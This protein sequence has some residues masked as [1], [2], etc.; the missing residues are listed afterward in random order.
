[1]FPAGALF[2]YLATVTAF[3][4]VLA[5]GPRAQCVCPDG[6]V[7]LF[8]PDSFAS[9]CCC[10]LSTADPVGAASSPGQREPHL[11]CARVK[12]ESS[13]DQTRAVERCGCHRV[14]VADA[15]YTAEE[16]GDGDQFE[17]GTATWT[18]RPIAPAQ[19]S[20][21]DRL[22]RRFLLPPPDRVILFR[23]FTC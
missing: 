21:F 23:H 18:G 10:D 13:A 22:E 1:M 12:P 11:C 17:A 3:L 14:L 9:K 6:R 16:A 4:T 19:T 8:C 5:G 20:R 2:K 7:K 15:A